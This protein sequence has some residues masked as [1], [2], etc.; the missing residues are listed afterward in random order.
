MPGPAA[1]ERGPGE[2]MI[3]GLVVLQA[4]QPARHMLEA[5]QGEFRRAWLLARTLQ[6]SRLA[7]PSQQ[8]AFLVGQCQNSRSALTDSRDPVCWIRQKHL[9]MAAESTSPLAPVVAAYWACFPQMTFAPSKSN[10][11]VI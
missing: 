9:V 8:L 1:W 3:E 2:E 5:L 7:S 6:G 11:P 10:S 4:T